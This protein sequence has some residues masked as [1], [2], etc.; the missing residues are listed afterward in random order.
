M[1][2]SINLK[3]KTISSTSSANYFSED[4][5]IF[6]RIDSIHDE[7][8]EV[9]NPKFS[10]IKQYFRKLSN[11]NII[12]SMV[13][14]EGQYLILLK[15]EK[16]IYIFCDRYCVRP[17]YY[18]KEN[19][20]IEIFD[21]IIGNIDQLSIKQSTALTF[22]LL[23]FI[24]GRQTLFSGISQI[25]PGEC[26]II[27][28]YDNKFKIN[29]SCVYPHK[30]IDLY[31]PPKKFHCLFRSGLEKRINQLSKNE[32]LLLPLSGGLDSR[33]L[34][35]TALEIIDSTRI[36]SMTYG[37][38][39]TY[40]Y[41]IGKK[42]AKTV[43]IKH[44]EYPLTKEN[45]N[46]NALINNCKDTDGQISFTTEAPIEIFR[47]FANYGN[48]ILSGFVGDA[49]VG[50]K[51]GENNSN[52][53]E[54]IVIKDAIVKG[55]DS[56]TTY[57]D[58][59]LIESSFYY[60]NSQKSSLNN[61]EYWFFINHFTKYSIHCVFKLREHFKYIN[62]FIDYKFADYAVNLPITLRE[63]QKLY[64]KLI[65]EKF[66]DFSNMPC[67]VYRGS[68]LQASEFK[69]FFD[70]QK[71]RILYYC[72]GKNKRINKIDLLRHREQILY[73]ELLREN[74]KDIIPAELVNKIFKKTKY[75]FLLYN[76][77]CL[78]IVRNYFGA[79]IVKTN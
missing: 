4:L 36:I 11:E 12:S 23:R 42:I 49:I 78:E 19:D 79:E 21:R 31:N 45:Y 34:L 17:I 68:P 15:K 64:R 14:V 50:N 65:Q 61:F 22:L 8:L 58:Q 2:I 73:P 74:M 75:H 24:P 33:Y 35:F 38:P 10:F 37:T 59:L 16:N 28:K 1:K 43:G 69:K 66:P 46:S 5:I 18:I 70:L 48:V 32:K 13:F 56:L 54:N 67:K 62:P 6:G 47:D 29:V 57:I 9:P 26:L 77:K 40:D 60:D 53:R 3:N 30:E 25:M 44:I 27:K 76:L 7:N 39:G 55:N 20:K 72:L 51:A 52:E 63:N 41:E 71:D